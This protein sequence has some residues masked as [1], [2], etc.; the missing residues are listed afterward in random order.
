[1][2]LDAAAPGPICS[3]Y[4][5]IAG[6]NHVD[7][8]LETLLAQELGGAA[9]RVEDDRRIVV[10]STLGH[11]DGCGMICGTGSSLSI[12]IGNEP[13]RQVG[14]LGYL[15]DTGGSGYE[16]GQAGLKEACRY[17]DGR[18]EYTVLADLITKALGKK[19]WDSLANIYAGG[20]SYIASFAHTV[21]EGVE[22]GDAVCRRIVEESAYKLSEL[23]FAAEKYFPGEFPVVMSGGIF[24]AYPKYVQLVCAKASPKARMILAVVPPVYGA[25]VEAMWQNGRTADAAVQRNFMGSIQRLE[26]RVN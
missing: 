10:S 1:R 3:I 19:P 13:I 22:M 5:G 7:M 15:I 11:A 18:G 21:F 17:L 26:S 9:V 23:T 12:I 20:R 16:L 14:G 2:Q 24:R 4:A 8:H 6:A 25:L